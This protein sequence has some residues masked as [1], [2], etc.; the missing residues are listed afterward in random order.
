MKRGEIWVGTET[1]DYLR[2]PRPWII[3]QGDR[4][5]DTDS[6]L[7]IPLT[8]LSVD[9]PLL[10]VLVEAGGTSGLQIDSWVML[11]KLNVMRR[12]R[13][14]KRIGTIDDG[15]LAELERKLMVVLGLAR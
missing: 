14:R 1:S 7:A 2:K 5:R 6:V 10:R 15:A 11:E 8:S 3:I 12:S 4:F 13:L 9:L